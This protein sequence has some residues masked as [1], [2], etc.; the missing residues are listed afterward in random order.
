MKAQLGDLKKHTQFYSSDNYKISFLKTHR[1]SIQMVC[2]FKQKRNIVVQV[3]E[4]WEIKFWV[5]VLILPS[6]SM[7]YIHLWVFG[8]SSIE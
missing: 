7:Y 6:I 4:H 1:I 2:A 5:P 3:A 8:F